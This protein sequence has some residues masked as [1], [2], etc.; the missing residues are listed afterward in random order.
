VTAP[1]TAQLRARPE[2][3]RLGGDGAEPRWTVRV[4]VPEVWDAV[5]F[6]APPTQGVLALKRRALEELFPD[7]PGGVAAFVLKLGGIEVLD[8]SASLADVGAANGS[9][10]LLTH[11]RRRPVR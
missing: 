4:Q 10:F 8:E 1:F 9:I 2:L 6:S 11:R 5:K 3:I 7:A